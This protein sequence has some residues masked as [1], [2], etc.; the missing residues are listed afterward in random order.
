LT[1][2]AVSSVTSRNAGTPF[3]AAA[4]ADNTNVA[5]LNSKTSASRISLFGF[6][7]TRSSQKNKKALRDPVGLAAILFLAKSFASSSREGS[8]AYG[9]FAGNEGADNS[10]GT[11]AD[12]HGLPRFPADNPVALNL[13]PVSNVQS[14][15]KPRTPA[16]QTMLFTAAK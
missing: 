15:S 16:C 12:S 14:E 6:P 2:L 8:L 13:Q 4:C 1:D 11:A 10:G 7:I 9:I 3:W 5:V